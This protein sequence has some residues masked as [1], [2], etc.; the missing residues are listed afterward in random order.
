MSVF[1]KR[2]GFTVVEALVAL[3]LVAIILVVTHL[4]LQQ[5]QQSRR[6][7]SGDQGASQQMFKAEGWLKRDLRG[8]A[9]NAL[10]TTPSISSLT[11][12]DGDA[13]WFLSAIDPTTGQFMRDTQ[14][15]PAWQRNVLYYCVVPTVTKEPFTGNGVDEGG[16]EA[17]HPYKLLIRKVIDSPTLIGDI[18]PFLDAPNG[19]VFSSTNHESVSIIA[20]RLLSFR[21][22][23]E[24]TLRQ[25]KL[26]LRAANLETARREFAI[27]SKAILDPR[28]TLER[29]FEVYPENFF[30]AP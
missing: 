24:D 29:S 18:S 6:K 26:I 15:H 8:T 2:S 23:T 9:Y 27:G 7:L 11:G 10:T 25:V 14:G 16:Y 19:Y 3:S 17:S 21:V 13:V 30:I 12:A 28:F 22:T 5:S 20:D 1:R 4:V